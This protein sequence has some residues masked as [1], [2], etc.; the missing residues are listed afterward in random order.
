MICPPW[1]Q[2]TPRLWILQKT[3]ENHQDDINPGDPRFTNQFLV[4][5]FKYF[6]FSTLLGEMIQFD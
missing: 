4:S 5:G 6:L 1:S 3:D 2:K